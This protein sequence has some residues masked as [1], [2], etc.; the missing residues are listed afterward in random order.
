[1]T[2]PPANAAIFYAPDMADTSRPKLMGRHAAGEGFIN[3]FARHGEV[4]R[5]YCCAARRAD[6]DDFAARV[7][8]AGGPA[9]EIAW[10]R[11]GAPAALA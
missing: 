11:Q 8:A 7:K 9:R 6:A 4:D 5:Y 10:V 1:M 3:A 2:R